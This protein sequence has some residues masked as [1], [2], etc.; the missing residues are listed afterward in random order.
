MTPYRRAPE[1][2]P[3]APRVALRW[4]PRAVPLAVRGVA[5]RGTGAREMASRLLELDDVSLRA[6]RGVSAG[7]DLVIVGE[8]PPWVPDAVWLGRDEGAVAWL[9]PTAVQTDPPV[10]LVLRALARQGASMTAPHAMWPVADGLRVV[11]LAEARPLA[12]ERLRAWA[13]APR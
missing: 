12:R 1:A 6:L 8:A 11:P 2:A 10:A 4:L 9:L 7:G 5:V 13:E 3:A